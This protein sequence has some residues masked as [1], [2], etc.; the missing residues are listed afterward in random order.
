MTVTTTT[1][2]LILSLYMVGSNASPSGFRG[3]R[4]EGSGR[5]VATAEVES[6]LR[7]SLEAVLGGGDGAAAK[8]LATIEARIWQTYQALPKNDV[9][10][11][12]PRGVRYLVHNYFA[13]EHGWLIKG[14][15]PHGNQAN[16]S[17]VHEMSILQD[18]A[19]ALVESL[20]EARRADH[21]LSLGDTVVMVAVLERLIFDESL[22]LL[23][24]SY[25]LN[26]QSPA[27]T[28]D[29]DSVH[30]VL[31]SY[32]L[33][34]EMSNKGNLTDVRGHQML[35][36]RA[37]KA[38]G[39][40]PT[41]VEYEQDAVFNYDFARQ[42]Q[43]N[44]FVEKRYS[45]EATAE[46]VEALTHGYGKWQN[47]EC[48]QMKSDLMDLDPDGTG[49]VPLSK[50]YSQPEG[51]EYQFTESV[52]YLRQIGALDETTTGGPRVRIANYMAGPSNC[53]AF[54]IYYFVCCVSDCEGLLNEL[55]A[56]VRAPTAQAERLLGLVSNMSSSTVDAP[57][58]S[59]QLVG[60]LHEI[61]ERNNGEVPLHGRLFAQ[62]LHHAFPNE[63]PYPHIAEEAAALTPSHWMD[64]STTAPKE[65]RQL[66]VEAHAESAAI[67]SEELAWN[68]EE[69]LHVHEAK[70]P[71]R[72][73]LGTV[74]RVSMQLA[75]LLGL[76]RVA[77]GSWQAAAAGARGT[78]D[79]K[80]K[81][82]FELPF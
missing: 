59:Q 47:T 17:E 10:R 1:V 4:A 9:G 51:A 16:V 61:A 74:V 45:F 76:L 15:E 55:E 54:F 21:G 52:D 50:F 64:K 80:A 12:A 11:L 18:K 5:T 57:R 75:M 22:A 36:S 71:G 41:M 38:G 78:K 23:Q 60:K 79:G 39:S 29:E 48:R 40:W 8:Q 46:I 33:L 26:R 20:L 35:K 77:L 42:P 19:P 32:L 34:F 3:G 82:A 25:T 49:R 69:V 81:V 56:K 24:A 28:L 67:I 70:Q 13:R 6:S 62:W 43:T 2:A 66:A 44:P 68:P 73:M 58:L 31:T 30:E 7:E 14:L 65:Q 72:S 37:A 53:I 63:C 27:E